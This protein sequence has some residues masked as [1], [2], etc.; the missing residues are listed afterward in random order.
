MALSAG[1]DGSAEGEIHDAVALARRLPELTALSDQDVM[2]VNAEV[3]AAV[4]LV[5]GVL[6]KIRAFRASLVLA[7]AGYDFALFD[8]LEEYALALN[9]A[10]GAYLVATQPARCS[11]EI[12]GEA[13]GLRKILLQDLKALAARGL[14]DPVRWKALRGRRGY[15]HLATDLN[16]LALLHQSCLSLVNSEL[17][18]TEEAL[19]SKR[20]LASSA[21]LE[22]AF[23]L[24]KIILRAAGRPDRK[25]KEVL[26]AAD[27]RARAFTLLV[28][29]Y[30]EV[31][32]CIAFLRSAEGDAE[33]IA[34]SLWARRDKQRK[35]RQRARVLEEES[36]ASAQAA[37]VAKAL[38]TDLINRTIADA[39]SRIGNVNG[40]AND[41]QPFANDALFPSRGKPPLN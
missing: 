10:H 30:E 4:A 9:A 20:S 24:V 1:A 33:L 15:L 40:D 18:G 5:L 16:I 26:A 37:D 36:R 19:L 27:M 31:R 12:L 39:A 8:G 25:S 7:L 29:A 13:R 3:P 6:P 32:R 21:E 38:N 17:S 41:E 34:P 22:R 11:R 35:A 14:V 23:E 2:D 28:R